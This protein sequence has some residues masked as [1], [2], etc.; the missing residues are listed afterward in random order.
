MKLKLYAVKQE[1]SE[2]GIAVVAASARQAKKLG[3]P[4]IKELTEMGGGEVTFPWIRARLKKGISVPPNMQPQAF[5]TCCEIMPWGAGAF[6][7]AEE[8]GPDDCQFFRVCH[9]P[10]D[11]KWEDYPEGMTWE[12]YDEAEAKEGGE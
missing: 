9:K 2:W 6:S 7:C 3:W 5:E 11:I 4:V 8:L 10:C 12:E 1:D